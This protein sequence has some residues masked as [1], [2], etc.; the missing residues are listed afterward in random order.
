MIL[1]AAVI[2]M[3][4]VAMS[5]ASNIIN[6]KMAQNEFNTNEQFMQ[7]TGLQIDDVAWTI[8][9]TQTVS[10]SSRF[11]QVNFEPQVLSYTVEVLV[12]STWQTLPITIETG[13]VLYN[14]PVGS[15]SM[16]NGYFQRIPY[17]ANNSFLQTGS[18]A[19][20]TQV[21]ATEKIPMTKGNYLR[22]VVVPTVRVLDS[23]SANCYK[24]Y[25][26]TMEAGNHLYA[27]QSITLSGNGISKTVKSGVD[28]IRIT[29][30]FPKADQ[31]FDSSFFNFKSITETK[32]LPHNSLV[33]VYVGNLM[34]T[35][36]Q[37]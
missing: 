25:L 29:A 35:I 15:Y 34:V 26:P 16:G 10:Y 27:T 37:V 9:R 33:E 6:M 21:Y 28:Q 30:S 1:T 11:G 7:T 32:T 12:G 3:I 4:L 13:I 14:V 23:A 19:P 8:G 2:V 36:G 31:G 17:D 20:I 5:Y 22:V 18:T 24:I